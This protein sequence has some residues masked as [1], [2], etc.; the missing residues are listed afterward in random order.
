MF[1]W[2][3]SAAARNAI[4]AEISESLAV[5]EFNIDGTTITANEN[6]LKALG[7]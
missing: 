6:F 3:S 2:R 5:I 1:G 7:Y 4:A